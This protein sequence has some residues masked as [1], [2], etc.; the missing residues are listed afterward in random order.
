MKAT[1]LTTIFLLIV[2]T[3]SKLSFNCNTTPGDFEEIQYK[4]GDK[5][6]VCIHF[7]PYGVKVAYQIE[8]DNYVSLTL[9]RGYDA[10]SKTSTDLFLQ[11]ENTET[12]T[13]LSVS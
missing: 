6:I 13:N 11:V 7:L 10:L 12:Y 4:K 5:V 9:R 3:L 1:V 8:V 2:T